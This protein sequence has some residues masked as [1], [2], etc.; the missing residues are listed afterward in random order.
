MNCLERFNHYVE[1]HGRSLMEEMHWGIWLLTKP[2][3]LTALSLL[4]PEPAI[5]LG[6]DVFFRHPDG[7]PQYGVSLGRYDTFWR[8]ELQAGESFTMASTRSKQQARRAIES[9]SD[10]DDGFL[11][12][13]FSA[14]DFN[15]YQEIQEQKRFLDAPN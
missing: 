2:D 1:S 6:G 7:R 12:I 13:E 10:D 14:C 15:R 11:G 8:F 5:V 3:A 9:Y 4:D